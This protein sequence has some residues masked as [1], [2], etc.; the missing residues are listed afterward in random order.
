MAPPLRSS[1]RV[2]RFQSSSR[3]IFL[4]C[5][6]DSFC[7]SFDPQISQSKNCANISLGSLF[8]CTGL[9]GAGGAYGGAY[10]GAYGEA[11]GGAYGGAFGEAYGG[12][13]SGVDR[14]WSPPYRFWARC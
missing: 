12:L 7:C 11:F 1:R 5:S 13:D 2:F 14:L 3:S 8:E 10:D 9:D 6:S 4:I